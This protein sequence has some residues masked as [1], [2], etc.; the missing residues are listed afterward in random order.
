MVFSHNHISISYFTPKTK[1]KGKKKMQMEVFWGDL[2]R[3]LRRAHHLTQDE[4]ASILHTTRQSVSN[5][6]TGR[7]QPTPEV[8]AVLSNIYDM[9]LIDYATQCMPI[10]YIA[11]Q[12]S[13]KYN[14]PETHIPKKDKKV[15]DNAERREKKRQKKKLRL[16]N[17]TGEEPIDL[18]T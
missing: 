1:Q 3:T 14:M 11:E 18:I 16:R 17:N 2:F 7:I 6:E 9:D 8:I 5:L 13:F 4:V 12:K 15:L 10:E